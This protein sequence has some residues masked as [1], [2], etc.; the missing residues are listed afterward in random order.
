M[1]NL[2]S[3]LATYIHILTWENVDPNYVY[4]PYRVQLYLELERLYDYV[5]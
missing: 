2:S 3:I 1:C 5:F 4:I